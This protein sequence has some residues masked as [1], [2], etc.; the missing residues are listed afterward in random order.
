MK[1]YRWW[2]VALTLVFIACYLDSAVAIV[3]QDTFPV[4]VDLSQ[5]PYFPPIGDQGN[6]GSCASWSV[7]YYANGFLQAKIH[8]WNDTY[9]GNPSHL[10]SPSWIYNKVNFNSDVNIMGSATT[11]CID[12]ILS[13]GAA[14]MTAMPYN[15]NNSVDWG[16]ESAWRE[17]PLYRIGGY[18]QTTSNDI[19]LIKSW[20]KEEHLV[21]FGID[22]TQMKA[23]ISDDNFVVSY[24]E[25]NE[26]KKNHAVTIVGYNDSV[27]DDGDRGAFKVANSW[28]NEWGDNGFFWM[29]YHAMDK[30]ASGLDLGGF[31]DPKAYRLLPKNSDM[32]PYQPK[33]LGVWE[34]SVAPDATSSIELGIGSPESPVNTRS[35]EWIKIHSDLP[36]FMCLDISEFNQDFSSGTRDFY[37]RIL[38]GIKI[39]VIESFTIES[40]D[41]KYILGNPIGISKESTGP[42]SMTPAIMTVNFN[43]PKADFTY[44]ASDAKNNQIFFSDK[45]ISSEGSITKWV[46]NFG[47][48][49]I[50]S[51]Q[52][53]SHT[54]EKLGEYT[55]K[56][57]AVDETGDKGICGSIITI[58]SQLESSGPIER[59]TPPAGG[60]FLVGCLLFSGMLYHSKRKVN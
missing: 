54:Y 23:G 29:T 28:G 22:S 40:Y 16:N 48:G 6:L 26:T 2:A 4:E 41:E 56:L 39:G 52:N 17:A 31:N 60:V 51:E 12:L 57:I 33:L 14:S 32:S 8:E 13:V 49:E 34:F 30:I 11:W 18:E 50:S 35:P 55:V 45:S 19:D 53:P 58:Q 27:S 5:M 36:T 15:E 43:P 42:I 24:F 44:M 20:I 7:G 10:M 47:D 38:P 9:S 3:Q 59:T 1:K 21:S 37:L 25:Y 46:W